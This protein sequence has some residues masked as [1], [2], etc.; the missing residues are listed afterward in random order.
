MKRNNKKKETVSKSS[1]SLILIKTNQTEK[2][3]G[4]LEKEKVAYEIYSSETNLKAKSPSKSR[5]V[6]ELVNSLDRAR[7]KYLVINNK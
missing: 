7:I 3:K 2:V 5:N 6:K 1:N 4:I